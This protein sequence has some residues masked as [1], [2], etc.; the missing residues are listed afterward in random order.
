MDV[1]LACAVGVILFVV[2]FAFG[3]LTLLTGVFPMLFVIAFIVGLIAGG[4][5]RGSWC[6]FVA[7]IIGLAIGVAIAPLIIA[8][9]ADPDMMLIGVVILTI[10]YPLRGTYDVIFDVSGWEALG[11][12]IMSLFLTPMI[13]L[14]SLFVG[15]IGGVVGGFVRRRMLQTDMGTDQPEYSSTTSSM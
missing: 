7:L 14:A 10:Y 13:Y 3:W 12:F 1:I 5:K 9:T 4:F 11:A 15:G 2:D 6:T 8:E